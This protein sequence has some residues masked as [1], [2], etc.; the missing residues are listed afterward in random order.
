MRSTL[1]VRSA[2]VATLR[3]GSPRRWCDRPPQGEVSQSES[4]RMHH[5]AFYAY[6][7]TNGLTCLKS[8]PARE[9]RICALTHAR[10]RLGNRRKTDGWCSMPVATRNYCSPRGRFKRQTQA[11]LTTLDLEPRFLGRWANACIGARKRC[12]VSSALAVPNPRTG[13]RE[14]PRIPREPS[15]RKSKCKCA[16]ACV[17]KSLS[18]A[19]L[20]C[21]R[22]RDPASMCRSEM[23]PSHDARTGELIRN[24]V[25]A[26]SRG[27][28]DASRNEADRRMQR[29]TMHRGTPKVAKVFNRTPS[30]RAAAAGD[31]HG[32]RHGNNPERSDRLCGDR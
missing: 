1:H 17:T 14:S 29:V 6:V 25:G 5:R 22:S 19:S 9:P 7:R 18:C 30:Q 4:A 10:R 27:E 31:K 24:K 32:K 20:G 23:S 3:N 11:M 15:P 8:A 28:H 13:I 2:C 21:T 12:L 16:R 26:R